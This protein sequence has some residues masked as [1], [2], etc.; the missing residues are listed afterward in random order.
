[1]YVFFEGTIEVNSYHLL[2]FTLGI[3]QLY[4]CN[5]ETQLQ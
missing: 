4:G 3:H 5:A 1:M 2:A